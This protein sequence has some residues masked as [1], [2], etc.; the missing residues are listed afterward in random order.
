MLDSQFCFSEGMVEFA[1]H[2]VVLLMLYHAFYT[3]V[4][5]YF[6]TSREITGF[7]IQRHC[8]G[9]SHPC[10]NE[11]KLL[12][13]FVFKARFCFFP[14]APTLLKMQKVPADIRK[15]LVTKTSRN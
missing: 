5:M 10:W 15:K 11:Q 1:T 7:H 12:F 3:E 9:E 4:E 8:I 2:W 6:K 14:A 13:L